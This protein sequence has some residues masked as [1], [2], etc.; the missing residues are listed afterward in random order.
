MPWVTIKLG[1]ILLLLLPC[2][3]FFFQGLLDPSQ[4]NM[5]LMTTINPLL[6]GFLRGLHRIRI[7]SLINSTHTGMGI[8]EPE[9][10]TTEAYSFLYIY[11]FLLQ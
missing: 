2:C 9:F 7:Y 4:P 3:F 10:T 6:T 8:L 5:V 11:H 1:E